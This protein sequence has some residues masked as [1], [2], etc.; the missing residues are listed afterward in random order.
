MGHGGNW[1]WSWRG[2]GLGRVRGLQGT[3]EQARD[4]RDMEMMEGCGMYA[5]VARGGGATRVVERSAGGRGGPPRRPPSSRRLR[6]AGAEHRSAPQKG[7]LGRRPTELRTL[8]ILCTGLAAG[9]KRSHQKR[10]Q[11]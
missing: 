9:S 1:A 11:A 3:A 4:A 8:E 2:A 5:G 10:G 6:A 7:R